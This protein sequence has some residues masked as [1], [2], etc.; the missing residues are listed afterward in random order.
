M[1]PIFSKSKRT[2]IYMRDGY[3]CWYCG[4]QLI[5]DTSIASA[6]SLSVPELMLLPTL[7]HLVPRVRGGYDH[8]NNL[9]TACRAC[10]SQKGKRTV[11]E[12]RRYLSVQL[13]FCNDVAAWLRGEAVE[14]MFWG[15]HERPIADTCVSA[16]KAQINADAA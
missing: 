7:D 6:R 1:K 15:E 4:R 16:D 12:Y 3:T 13:D 14:V 9:V 2:R 5:S 11:E 8:D 10:N